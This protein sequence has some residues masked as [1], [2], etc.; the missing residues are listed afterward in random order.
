MNL[1]YR[2]LWWMA[3]W[4]TVDAYARFAYGRSFKK[5]FPFLLAFAALMSAFEALL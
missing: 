2:L 1:L 4:T 5:S 3:F